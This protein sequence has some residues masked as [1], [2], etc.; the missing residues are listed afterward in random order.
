MNST[1]RSLLTLKR[2]DL[3]TAVL[4]LEKK[5]NYKLKNRLFAFSK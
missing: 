5:E 1:L 3:S 4:P 2:N